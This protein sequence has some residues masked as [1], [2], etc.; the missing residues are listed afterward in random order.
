MQKK[1]LLVDIRNNVY[2]CFVEKEIC[3][4]KEKN[5][6][7]RGDEVGKDV[8][9]RREAPGPLFVGLFHLNRANSHD[10]YLYIYNVR[11]KNNTGFLDRKVSLHT[12]LFDALS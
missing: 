9:K 6:I 11:R 4:G 8:K 3:E 10:T 1:R 2:P 7:A 12:L 5:Q